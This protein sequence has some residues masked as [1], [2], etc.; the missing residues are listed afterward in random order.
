MADSTH[1]NV[2]G[3][4]R[5]VDEGSQ[6]ES[7]GGQIVLQPHPSADPEDPLNWSKGRKLRAIGM[8][9]VYVLGIGLATTVQYSILTEIAEAQD[10]TVGNLNLGTGLMFLFLGWACLIWQPIAMTYGRRGVY[11]ASALLSIIPMVW[12]PYSKGAG[13][14]YAHR[15]L[16]GIFAA[17]VEALPEVSVPDLFFAHERGSFMALYAFILFGSNFLAPLLA[18]F[19]NDG[20]GWK[21]TMHFGSIVLG[22]TAVILFFFLEDTIYFRNTT[23]GGSESENDND[24]EKASGSQTEMAVAA[25]YPPP[26]TYRE[27]LNLVLRLPGRPT[28]KQTIGKSWRALCIIVFFPNIFWAGLLYGT[29]LSWYN[30]MNAT[31]SSILHGEPYNFAPRMVGVAYAS[32]LLAAAGSSFW[33]GWFADS[34]AVRLARRNNGIREPEQ[35]LWVLLLSGLF[36]AGGLVLWG[37]GASRNVHFMGLII[38]LFFVTFGVVTSSSV[39]LAYTVDCFKEIT[40]ESMIAVI[41]VRNTLSFAFNYAI[42]PWIDSLG[43]QNCFVSVS[44]IAL[45]CTFSFLP[46]VYVGKRLRKFSAAKYWEYIAEDKNYPSSH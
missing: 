22:V 5:L 32:P 21:W 44:L 13:Q 35:R 25:S 23:E 33:S 31:M 37:V 15:I 28:A 24:N 43:L 40:G 9:Y 1:H 3:T 20:V 42:N 39:A 41:I 17:P 4:I 19:I 36:S 6:G 45:V 30:V 8:V 18:G 16:L 46:M 29:N 11:I 34:M 26:R 27:K 2:P 38:G 10:L 7:G 12:A 14:W